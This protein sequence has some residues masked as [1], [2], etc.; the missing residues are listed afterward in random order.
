MAR[1]GAQTRAPFTAGGKALA[2]RIAAMWESLA[3]EHRAWDLLE[4]VLTASHGER[5]AR[6]G[7]LYDLRVSTAAPAR[8][9]SAHS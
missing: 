9:D 1:K 4:P 5:A 3:V 2:H 6:L 7:R 8:P